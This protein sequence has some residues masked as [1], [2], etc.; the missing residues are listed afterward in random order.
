[1]L[2]YYRKGKET[3]QK[4]EITYQ[5]ALDIVLSSFRDNDM[6]RDMLTLPNRII[7]RYSE[8]TVEDDKGNGN[9]SVLMAGLYN[10]LPDAVEYDDDGMRLERA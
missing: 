7:C 6:S 2:K 5:K 10:M 8:V 3:D 9:I 1:M 4:E